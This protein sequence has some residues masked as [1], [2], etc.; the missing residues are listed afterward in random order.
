MRDPAD[1]V[2][3]M[4]GPHHQYPDGAE[5]FLGTIFA[6]VKDRDTPGSGFT[7]KLGDV[8]T[9]SA[10][11][12][13]AL[14]NRMRLS[15]PC[16]HPQGRYSRRCLRPAGIPRAISRTPCHRTRDDFRR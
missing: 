5:L 4:I 6:P 7:H 3:Q 2:A 11:E 10:P 16:P 9:I 15:T 1:L 14:T 13:G 8:V 12:L